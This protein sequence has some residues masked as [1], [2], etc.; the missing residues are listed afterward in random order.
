MGKQRRKAPDP[1]P[2]S[3]E[4]PPC[5]GYYDK[6]E[7]ACDGNPAGKTEAERVPCLW[8]NHCRAFQAHL[9]HAGQSPA[10]HV[11]ENYNGNGR[12]IGNPIAGEE[13]FLE[14]LEKCLRGWQA[15]GKA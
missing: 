4:I 15:R 2:T 14:L 7:I 5:V 12:R 3:I 1:A 8:R 13:A 11:I 9:E 10:Q 6:N